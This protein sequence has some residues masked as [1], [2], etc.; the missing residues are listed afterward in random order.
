MMP[1]TS[2]NAFL[3]PESLCQ[4]SPK[5]VWANNSLSDPEKARRKVTH[6]AFSHMFAMCSQREGQRTVVKKIW[7]LAIEVNQVENVKF[8]KNRLT[9]LGPGKSNF[10]EAERDEIEAVSGGH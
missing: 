7:N 3:L 8:F 9:W 10:F 4:A 1:R 5:P 6:K 2:S